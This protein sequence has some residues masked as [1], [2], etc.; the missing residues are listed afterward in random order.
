M[1][2]FATTWTKSSRRSE[3]RERVSLSGGTKANRRTRHQLRNR[4]RTRKKIR[5][6]LVISASGAS[7]G[8]GASDIISFSSVSKGDGQDMKQDS[9]RTNKDSIPLTDCRKCARLPGCPLPSDG[10]DMRLCFTKKPE[11]A[12]FNDKKLF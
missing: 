6:I 12:K 8:Q 7:I 4:R 1:K 11:T 2:D 3:R 9:R 5:I 10:P